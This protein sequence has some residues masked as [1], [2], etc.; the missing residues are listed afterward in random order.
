VTQV[1]LEEG[2]QSP[3][4][5]ARNAIFLELEM[6]AVDGEGQLPDGAALPGAAEEADACGGKDPA[7][8]VVV[9]GRDDRRFERRSPER[10]RSET[11]RPV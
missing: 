11:D 9:D 2:T 1:S 6:R 10:H 4:R 7:R 5:L 3:R 8:Y